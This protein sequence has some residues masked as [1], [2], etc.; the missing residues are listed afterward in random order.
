M[1]TCPK[2]NKG[3]INNDTLQNLELGQRLTLK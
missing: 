2:E 1:K 3:T